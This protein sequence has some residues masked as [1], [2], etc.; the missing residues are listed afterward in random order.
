MESLRRELRWLGLSGIKTTY[1]SPMF[2]NTGFATNPTTRS[3]VLSPI[4]EPELVVDKV[5]QAFLTNQPSVDI[6]NLGL[7]GHVLE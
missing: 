1:A 3:S 7:L 4:L 5:M 6:P 2:V